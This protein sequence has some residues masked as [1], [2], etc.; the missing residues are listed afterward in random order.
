MNYATQCSIDHNCALIGVLHNLNADKDEDRE[1]ANRLEWEDR[2]FKAE[3]SGDF[4]DYDGPLSWAI[5]N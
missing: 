2:M 4:F 1:E 5:P 3:E